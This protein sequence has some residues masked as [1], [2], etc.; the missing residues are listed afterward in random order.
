MGQESV[1]TEQKNTKQEGSGEKTVK[2]E[3]APAPWARIRMEEEAKL[4]EDYAKKTELSKA[5]KRDIEKVLREEADQIRVEFAQRWFSEHQDEIKNKGYDFSLKQEGYIVRVTSELGGFEELR[6]K[7]GYQ[8]INEN[9]EN[10]YALRADLQKERIPLESQ[11]LILNIL[12]K[13]AESIREELGKE[14]QVTGDVATIET[15]KLQLE[16]LFKIRQELAEKISGR[17]LRKEAITNLQNQQG[18]GGDEYINSKEE[19]I[20]R[21]FDKRYSEKSAELKQPNENEPKDNSFYLEK[22]GYSLEKK[23]LLRKRFSVYD[24]EGKFLKKELSDREVTKF[25]HNKLEEKIQ[26]EVRNE[27]GAEWENKNKIWEKNIR[28]FIDSEIAQMAKSPESATEGIK[29]VYQRVRDRLIGEYIEQYLKQKKNKQQLETIKEK[30]EG[31]KKDLS[32]FITDVQHRRRDGSLQ[33][34]SGNIETDEKSIFNFLGEWGI[35]VPAN[36]EIAEDLK[37][38]YGQKVRQEIGFVE[39]LI[40]L[41]CKILD[42]VVNA[43][44]SSSAS[45]RNQ[46][47]TRRQ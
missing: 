35:S 2:V 10:L 11:F 14:L 25:L 4:I 27:L 12:N 21:K 33:Q 38:N 42:A 36:Y 19:Y 40:D 7:E 15:K 16:E 29:A 24:R 30:F 20:K 5:T 43:G 13:K 18:Q 17:D 34:L 44:E 6:T 22:L 37:S 23:G 47:P 26:E 8:E 31:E 9:I 28:N 46:R 3:R 32:E 41:I 1:P 39:W 45:S